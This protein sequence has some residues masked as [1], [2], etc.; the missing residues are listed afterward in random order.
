M[1]AT[2]RVE[3]VLTLESIERV[4]KDWPV[5]RT[6]TVSEFVLSTSNPT[7]VASPGKQR[8]VRDALVGDEFQDD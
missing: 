7:R 3:V 4:D 1:G 8:R 6:I 2:S 5:Y